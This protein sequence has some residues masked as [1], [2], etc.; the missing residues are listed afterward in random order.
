MS[1]TIA[2]EQEHVAVSMPAE[3]AKEAKLARLEQELLAA[4]AE[5]DTARDAYDN[6]YSQAQIAASAAREQHAVARPSNLSGPS[7]YSMMEKSKLV[8]VKDG[9]S[10]LAATRDVTDVEVARRH[11]ADWGQQRPSSPQSARSL[12]KLAESCRKVDQ[13]TRPR[14]QPRLEST[15]ASK[16]AS[17]ARWPG[18][19][20]GLGTRSDVPVTVIVLRK[21]T[22][23]ALSPGPLASS[24]AH[25][26]C[27]IFHHRQAIPALVRV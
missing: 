12:S 20:S 10:G 24:A 16:A 25:S 17:M 11:N 22:R 19:G 27:F 26:A 2:T 15:R 13:R 9:Y 14:I 3:E 7:A 6:A 21:S 8:R 1:T 23:C 5:V 18:S 4:Q